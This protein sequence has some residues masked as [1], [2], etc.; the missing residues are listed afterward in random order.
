MAKENLE[1]L[2]PEERI[3][4]LKELEKKRKQEIEEAKKKIKESESE[5]TARDEWIRKVPIPQISQEDLAGL[6]KEGKEILAVHKG[7]KEKKEVEDTVEE[8]VIEKTKDNFAD[9]EA[10]ARENLNISPEFMQSAYTQHLSQ[11]PM[12][13][14]YHEI[15][16]IHKTVEEKGYISKEE[17]RKVEY[18]A[19]A[20]EKK[21]E[22]AESGKYSFTEDVAK[23]ANLTRAIGAKLRGLYQSSGTEYQN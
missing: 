8:K 5:L 14:I 16:D 3:K 7:V 12:N 23:A 4:K 11:Q 21:V 17:E 10:L 22:D 19:S 1:N 6:S 18:L 13:D 20:V 2:P 15:K 9:L